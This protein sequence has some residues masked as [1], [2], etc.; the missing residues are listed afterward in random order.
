MTKSKSSFSN[1]SSS[2][3]KIDFH[4]IRQTIS[5]SVSLPSLPSLPWSSF[6]W[7]TT[8]AAAAAARPKTL[9]QSWQRHTHFAKHTTTT[10]T[11]TSQS[12]WDSSTGKKS[13]VAGSANRDEVGCSRVP[14]GTWGQQQRRQQKEQEHDTSV[15]PKWDE[16]QPNMHSAVAAAEAPSGPESRQR[17]TAPPPPPPLALLYDSW[18]SSS[19]DGHATSSAAQRLSGLAL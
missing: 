17:T 16:I 1:S 8:A 15:L 12:V 10:T 2:K 5:Q 11:T 19:H 18:S 4:P 7:P 13:R 6:S 3:F 9:R 14:K